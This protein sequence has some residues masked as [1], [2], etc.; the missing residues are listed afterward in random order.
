MNF[1]RKMVELLVSKIYYWNRAFA[2][3]SFGAAKR[4]VVIR[5]CSASASELRA[6]LCLK[7]IASVHTS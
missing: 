7:Q 4:V 5:S 6:T 2:F 1:M 3:L